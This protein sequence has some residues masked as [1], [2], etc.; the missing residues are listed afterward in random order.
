MSLNEKQNLQ[1]ENVPFFA[2][3]L[4]QQIVELSE[5]EMETIVGGKKP[6]SGMVTLRYPNDIDI[7]PGPIA[8]TMKYPSDGDDSDIYL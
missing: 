3:Y 1:Q 8:V 7:C 5:E 2:R 6:T 4:E